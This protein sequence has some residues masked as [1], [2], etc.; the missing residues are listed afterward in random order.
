[1]RLKERSDRSGLGL[2]LLLTPEIGILIPIL[3][4]CVVTTILKPNFLTW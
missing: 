2:K 1:M 3:I 4:L